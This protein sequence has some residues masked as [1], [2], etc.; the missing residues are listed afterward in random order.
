MNDCKGHSCNEFFSAGDVIK[1]GQD[2]HLYFLQAVLWSAKWQVARKTSYVLCLQCLAY[3]HTTQTFLSS[4]VRYSNPCVNVLLFRKD[5]YRGKTLP[6]CCTKRTRRFVWKRIWQITIFVQK[7]TGYALAEAISR[8]YWPCH[9]TGAYAM[10]Q[11]ISRRYWPCHGSGGQS[12]AP[13]VPWL[14]R[15]VAGIGRA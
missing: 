10:A 1:R 4:E 7:V 9:G 14:R 13:A 8:R 3:L 5:K 2:T 15:L 6:T 12:P 11:A